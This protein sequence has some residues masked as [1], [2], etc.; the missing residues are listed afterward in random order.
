MGTVASAQGDHV[1]TVSAADEA[2]SLA[3]QLGGATDRSA[4]LRERIVA[5]LMNRDFEV[6][7]QLLRERLDLAIAVGNGVGASSCRLNLAY[8]ANETRRHETASASLLW[9]S[10]PI[11]ASSTTRGRTDVV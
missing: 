7:E 3:S 1:T 10:F 11:A 6:A 4:V 2:A 9:T 8:I 5:A